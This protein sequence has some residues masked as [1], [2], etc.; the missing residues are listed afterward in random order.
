MAS[1]PPS[2][3]LTRLAVAFAAGLLGVAA[4]AQ[5]PRQAEKI[6]VDAVPVTIN[7]KENTA[8]LRDVVITQGETRIQADEAHVRGGIKFENGEWTISGN[9]RIKAEGGNLRSD[10]AVVAFRDNL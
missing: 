9:V 6:V 8:V 3:R 1:S 5:N 10:K 2:K 7:T 4:A